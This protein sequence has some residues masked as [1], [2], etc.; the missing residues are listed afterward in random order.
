MPPPFRSLRHGSAADPNGYPPSSFLVGKPRALW[1]AQPP[2]Y[3]YFSIA[4][5]GDD[6]EV[7]KPFLVVFDRR[8]RRAAHPPAFRTRSAC[9]PHCAPHLLRTCSEL[10]RTCSA[11]V[12]HL[13]RTCAALVPHLFRTC[14]ALVPHLCRTCAALVPRM[15]RTCAALVPQCGRICGAVSSDPGSEMASQNDRNKAAK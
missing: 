12:P 14:A 4:V 7:K 13:F 11:L 3:F 5:L 2:F 8:R 15:C 10:C 6:C 1:A 9:D